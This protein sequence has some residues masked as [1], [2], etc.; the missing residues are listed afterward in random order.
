MQSAKVRITFRTAR[1][2]RLGVNTSLRTCASKR[3]LVDFPR[4][5]THQAREARLTFDNA[6]S[7][8]RRNNT[9]QKQD[10]SADS[11]CMHRSWPPVYPSA[12]SI[13]K[14]ICQRLVLTEWLLRRS[15]M[16][17]KRP[18]LEGS[19]GGTYFGREPT[20]NSG[21][22]ARS[23]HKIPYKDWNKDDYRAYA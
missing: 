16:Q 17:S 19:D 9:C 4:K 20:M 14:L 6:T 2:H 1:L 15:V 22:A 11:S 7:Y 18:S 3:S 13:D 12:S 23:P 10:D 21:P 5:M 8:Q